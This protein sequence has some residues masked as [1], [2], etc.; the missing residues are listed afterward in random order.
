M[1]DEDVEETSSTHLPSEALAKEDEER[2]HLAFL[3]R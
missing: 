3:A 1:R 2:S